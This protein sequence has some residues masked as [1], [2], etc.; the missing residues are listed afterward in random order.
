MFITAL[1]YT[2]QPHDRPTRNTWVGMCQGGD[3]V[4]QTSCGEF[5]SHPIQ[6]N[7]AGIKPWIIILH[8]SKAVMQRVVNSHIAGSNPA[9]AAILA[10]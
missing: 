6:F 5:D 3:E 2:H 7:S 9:D 4:L 1:T 8:R 10:L